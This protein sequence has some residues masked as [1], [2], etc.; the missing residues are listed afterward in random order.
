M[1]TAVLDVSVDGSGAR[2]P[3]FGWRC[4][5]GAPAI[6]SVLVIVPDRA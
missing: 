5:Q 4:P 1:I 3:P 6:G 2:A